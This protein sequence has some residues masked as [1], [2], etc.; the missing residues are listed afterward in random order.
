MQ[1]DYVSGMSRLCLPTQV[2]GACILFFASESWFE[3]LASIWPAPAT[4]ESRFT[5]RELFPAL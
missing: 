2:F 3:G 1:D 5:L 4:L